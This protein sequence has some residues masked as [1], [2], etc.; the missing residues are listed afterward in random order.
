VILSHPGP[1]WPTKRGVSHANLVANA[2]VVMET[3]SI[4]LQVTLCSAGCRLFHVFGQTCGLNASVVAGARASLSCHAS[5]AKALADSCSASLTVFQAYRTMYGRW[6]T[7]RIGQFDLRRC[8]V[9]TGGSAMP[10]R[11]C[12][13]SKGISLQCAGRIRLDGDF[14]VASFNLLIGRA[15]QDRSAPRSVGWR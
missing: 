2:A 15:S 8:V 13:G 14:A 6:S 9:L 1:P 4:S 7:T 5:T 3:C 12:E 10:W 11:S